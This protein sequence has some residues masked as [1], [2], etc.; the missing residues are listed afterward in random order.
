M[1]WDHRE[2]KSFRLR[3]RLENLKNIIN[4]PLKESL[5][6]T[7]NNI[8]PL[9]LKKQLLNENIQLTAISQK[10]VKLLLNNNTNNNDAKTLNKIQ[11]SLTGNVYAIYKNNNEHL[12][13]RNILIHK[14]LNFHFLISNNIIYRNK[15]QL[16]QEP[17]TKTMFFSYY[18]SEIL[19]PLLVLELIK[20][21]NSVI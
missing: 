2:I 21:H 12:N 3:Y 13:Y 10:T 16:L 1:R 17:I 18:N 5:F 6:V 7:L 9:A 4:V 20:K 8:T 11:N 19:K 15:E 14:N